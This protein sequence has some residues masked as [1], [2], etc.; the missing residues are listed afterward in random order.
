MRSVNRTEAL[1]AAVKLVD[2]LAPRKDA[3]GYED[4]SV[5]AQTR[6]ALVLNV[7][8]WLLAGG[9]EPCDDPCGCEVCVDARALAA[10]EAPHACYKCLGT[11]GAIVNENYPDDGG[12]W[13]HPYGCPAV[14]P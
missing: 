14:S 10:G 8:D 13:A 6:V 12:R 7:A 1:A 11:T 3:K 4:R 5:G 2:E 9:D